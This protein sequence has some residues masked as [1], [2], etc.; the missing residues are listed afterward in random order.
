MISIC[1]PVFNFDVRS[2]VRMLH[3]QIMESGTNA[4]IILIDD[5]SADGFKDFNR[6]LAGLERVSYYELEKK[7]GRSRIRNLLAE[8]AGRDWLLFLDCDSGL[9]EP[10]FVQRYLE[11]IPCNAVVCGGRVYQE[12]LADS[13]YRLHWWYGRN[14]EAKPAAKRAQ[15]PYHSFM[16]NNFMAPRTVLLKIPFNEQLTGYGHE[17]TLFGYELM[18]HKIAVRHIDN[19]LLHIG[20]DTNREFLIKSREGVQNLAFIFQNLAVGYDFNDM[21]KLLAWYHKVSHL[22]LRRI[23][24]FFFRLIKKLLERNLLGNRPKLFIFD[25]Y[26]LGLMLQIGIHRPLQKKRG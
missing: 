9:P 20:L 14:R 11:H 23:I 18:Q 12:K 19:P 8:K 25:F 1:I 7:A 4:E 13:N 2:L 16:T 3:G 10:F 5:N 6:E 15:S 24:V 22:G 26:K 21:S 17:D